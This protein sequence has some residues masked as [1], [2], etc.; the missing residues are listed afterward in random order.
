[1]KIILS[2]SPKIHKNSKQKITSGGG[3]HSVFFSNL[4]FDDF[5]TIS[6]LEVLSEFIARCIG[7]LFVKFSFLTP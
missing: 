7:Q 1:M 2:I 6:V 5:R 4:S 3:Y